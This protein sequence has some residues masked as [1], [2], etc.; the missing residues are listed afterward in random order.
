MALLYL[1]LSACSDEIAEPGHVQDILDGVLGVDD[2]QLVV[3]DCLVEGEDRSESGARQIAD[4]I[5]I[6]GGVLALASDDSLRLEVLGGYGVQS[7]GE[8]DDDG[9][10]YIRVVHGKV[11]AFW[12][13]DAEHDIASLKAADVL[14]V[15]IR[16]GCTHMM[17]D[18]ILMKRFSG[19]LHP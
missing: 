7:S 19:W 1:N 3:A 14:T 2:C 17:F 10:V 15:D 18:I 6:Q 11:V 9:S 13:L 12:F 5:H 4:P 8:S 16:F